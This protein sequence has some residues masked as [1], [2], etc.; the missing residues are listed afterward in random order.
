[1]TY[2]ESAQGQTITKARAFVELARHGVNNAETRA[3]MVAELGD[4]AEYDAGDV[5]AFLGY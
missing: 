3:D 4:R 2:S 1:M 5:L